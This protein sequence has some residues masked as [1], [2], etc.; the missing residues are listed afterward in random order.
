MNPVIYYHPEAYTT[1]GPKLMGRNA[2]GESFLRGFLKHSHSTAFWA[3]VQ[4]NEHGEH[5]AKQVK[6]LGRNEPIHC[7]TNHN[8]NALS[9]AGLVYHP[10][11][12][13]ASTP[14]TEVWRASRALQTTT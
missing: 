10:G 7:I 3:Q 5:F 12:A 11:L 9:Q 14:F 1:T 6:A 2:A 13:L 4:R 8:L